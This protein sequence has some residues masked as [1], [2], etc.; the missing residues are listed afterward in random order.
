VVE[1]RGRIGDWEGDLIVGRSSRSAIGTL[2]DRR[3]G[4]LRLVHPPDGHSAERLRVAMLPILTDLPAQ[5]RQTLTRDQGSEMA[6]HHLLEMYFADGI[7]FAPPA[8]PWLR[9]TNENTNGLLRQYFPEGSDLRAYTL[10]DLQAVEQRIN[11]RPRQRLA[12]R[13]PARVMETELAG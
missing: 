9:G 11:D 10:A 3:T 1:E 8:S 4:Y 5:A 12:W 2:V 6:C 7:F 13:S